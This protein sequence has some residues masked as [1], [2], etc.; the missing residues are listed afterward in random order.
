MKL[1]GKEFKLGILG[2]LAKRFGD[3][4]DAPVAKAPVD[5]PM[6][7][8][9]F[10]LERAVQP[11]V[12]QFDLHNIPGQS[13]MGRGDFEAAAAAW[14]QLAGMIEFTSR[15][16]PLKPEQKEK[17]EKLQQALQA[18]GDAM[19]KAD[20]GDREVEI[21]LSNLIELTQNWE[22]MDLAANMLGVVRNHLGKV[23]DIS[24]KSHGDPREEY[25]RAVI[26]AKSTIEDHLGYILKNGNAT[27]K[28]ARE[29]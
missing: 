22:C 3:A 15:A 2:G 14:Q 19:D 24:G 23:A 27:F 28:P 7:I 10:A 13:L 18:I 12:D 8:N 4:K 21:P 5:K 11:I 17:M 20:L 9:R 6:L 25:L 26:A 29:R 16:Y 1:F